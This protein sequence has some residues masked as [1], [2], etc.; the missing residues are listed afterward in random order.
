MPALCRTYVGPGPVPGKSPEI[1]YWTWALEANPA[2]LEQAG[3]Q[4]GPDVFHELTRF[5]FPEEQAIWDL[6]DELKAK[7]KQQ[8]DGDGDDEGAEVVDTQESEFEQLLKPLDGKVV[9]KA[10]KHFV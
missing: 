4:L 1:E 10:A 9:K 3:V 8:A 6:K 5:P 2:Y 7:K